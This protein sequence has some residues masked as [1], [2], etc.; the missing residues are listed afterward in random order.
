MRRSA[1]GC[2]HE[3]PPSDCSLK[4]AVTR[5]IGA[6]AR[7]VGLP[8]NHLRETG[9]ARARPPSRQ[10]WRHER[11][12]RRPCG[13]TAACIAVIA[14][15]TNPDHAVFRHEWRSIATQI[16]PKTC[17]PIQIANNLNPP[18]TSSVRWHDSVGLWLLFRCRSRTGCIRSRLAGADAPCLRDHHDPRL[19]CLFRTRNV[20]ALDL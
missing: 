17:T 13:E 15:E 20:V 16:R 5:P 8:G 19:I 1:C 12:S 10:N 11:R 14:W 4:T 2:S 18:R 3:R 7:R 9:R 6:A